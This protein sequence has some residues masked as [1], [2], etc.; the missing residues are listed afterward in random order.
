MSLDRVIGVGSNLVQAQCALAGA[1]S[2]RRLLPSC[3]GPVF[4]CGISWA[5][6]NFSL[7]E[8]RRATSMAISILSQIVCS[9]FLAVVSL[10][11]VFLAQSCFSA[12]LSLSSAVLFC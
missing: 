4:H 6:F 9:D 12:P 8:G 10:F 7:T 3:V 2:L 5:C 1:L 11:V